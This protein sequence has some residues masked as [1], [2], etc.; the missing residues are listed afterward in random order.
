MPYEYRGMTPEEREDVVEMRCLRGWPLHSPPHPIR[1]AGKY[2]ITAANFEHKLIM[3]APVRRTDFEARL[4]DK[5]KEIG[6][7]IFAWAVLANHYHTLIGVKSLDDVSAALK[8]LHGTTSHEWNNADGMT[9]Q[10]KVWYRFSDR[11]IRDD[12]HFYRALNYV[13]F[14]PAKHG[15]VSSVYDWPWSSV[16]NYFDAHGREWLREQWQQ[17]PPDRMGQGWD[18]FDLPSSSS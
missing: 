6:A 4:L 12:R 8:T 10:R 17:Y 16:H 11:K 7:V 2:L 13:H 1:S 3:S 15:Y 18:D 9:G 14:N 5:L